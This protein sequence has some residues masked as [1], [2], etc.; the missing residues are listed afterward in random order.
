MTPI[1]MSRRRPN[2]RRL[3]MY[4][5]WRLLDDPLGLGVR[6]DGDGDGDGDEDGGIGID[7]GAGMGVDGIDGVG[8]V[9]GVDGVHG[10]GG[11]GVPIVRTT[12][13]YEDLEA[14]RYLYTIHYI[15]IKP[16]L[17]MP[18]LPIKPILILITHTQGGA[19]EPTHLRRAGRMAVHM[20]V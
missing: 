7:A 20:T 8:G 15:C 14:H 9:D 18:H 2:S 10:I 19:A 6:G 3:P 16:S 17:S 13:T 5:E 12:L 4:W 11:V 1:V